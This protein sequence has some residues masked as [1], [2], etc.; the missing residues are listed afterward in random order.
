MIA[1]V[2]PTVGIPLCVDE[3]GRW[4]R[5]RTYQYGDV[6]YARAVERAGGLPIYL[7]IQADAEALVARIDALLVPG[8]DD[9]LPPRAYPAHVRFEPVPEHQLGFDRALVDAALRRRIPVL[10][11]CYGMQLVAL[12]RGGTL[13]YDLAT[14]LPGALEHQLGEALHPIALEPGSKL[15]GILGSRALPVSSRHHQAVSDPGPELRIAARSTDG[16][17]EALESPAGAFCVGV[18]WHPESHEG[19]ESDALFRAFVAAAQRG[20]SRAKPR[21]AKRPA[22]MAE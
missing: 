21:A 3:Q 4:K 11:I 22:R 19:A 14:D 17:I 20:R 15:A 7:P 10:G 18:Q 1:R 12:A 5:G 6:T 8:G 16:V 9:F 2:V 13:H